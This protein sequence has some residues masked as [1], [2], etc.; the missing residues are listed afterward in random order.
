MTI[1]SVET[2]ALGCL[3][4]LCSAGREIDPSQ[5]AETN[6]ESLLSGSVSVLR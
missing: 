4:E 5:L 3:A 2:A 1:T 6:R